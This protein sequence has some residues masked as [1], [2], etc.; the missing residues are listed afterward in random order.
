MLRPVIY[1]RISK[2]FDAAGDRFEAAA[3]SVPGRLAFIVWCGF[4]PRVDEN[5]ANYGIS[6]YT[7]AIL[8]FTIPAARRNMKALHAKVDDL[9]CAVDKANST[10]ARIED[11][12]EK[13]IDAKRTQP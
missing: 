11:L 12:T 3:G 9:E 1:S 7:A 2:L 5:V 8:V 4:A 10:N 6:V 13:E